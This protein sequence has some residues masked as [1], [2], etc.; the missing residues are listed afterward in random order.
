MSSYNIK[1]DFQIDMMTLDKW[2]KML[3]L[4]GELM[5][6]P[7]ALIMKLNQNNLEVL[8]KSNHVHNV[9][10]QGEQAALGTGL[11]CETVV[12]S[13]KELVVTNA[14]KD[15][16]WCNNPDLCRSMISYMGFPIIWPTGEIFGTIC[17]LDIREREYSS[18]YERLLGQFAQL[19]QDDLK[20]MIDQ[21]R[22]QEEVGERGKAEINLL[23]SEEKFKKLF[24]F[25]PFPITMMTLPEGI[26]VDINEAY[27]R[28]YGSGRRREEMIGKTTEQLKLP[29][30]PKK[31]GAR[32]KRISDNEGVPDEE[33]SIRLTNGKIKNVIVSSQKVNLSGTDHVITTFFDITQQKQNEIALQSMNER[34]SLA[35]R[36]A[37][38]GIW[39]W[40]LLDNKLIWNERMYEIYGLD[41]NQLEISYEEWSK[42]L[43]PDD[44]TQSIG[45][46]NESISNGGPY[47][48]EYRA[49]RPDGTVVFIKAQGDIIPD[50]SGKPIRM[51]GVN[52][53]ITE[54]RQMEEKVL[55]SEARYKSLFNHKHIVK[56][57]IDVES[58]QIVEANEAACKFYGFSPDEMITKKVWDINVAGEA[59]VRKKLW[60]TY[61][62]KSNY[63]E[64]KHR[65]WDGKIADVAVFSG[66][67][68]MDH[69]KMVYALIT[70]ITAKKEL[71]REH[72]SMVAQ[73]LQKQ[74][75]ES[76]GL[77]A[78]GVAHEINNP[79]FGII[80]YAKLIGR[81]QTTQEQIK[82]YSSEIVIES[83]R[84]A[85]IVK[86]L[87]NFSRQ[88]KHSYSPAEMIDIINHTVALVQTIFKQDQIE[89]ILDI[90]PNLPK[91]I[92]RS[93]QIQQVILN[94]ITNGRD[95]L[96]EKYNGYDEN[97]KIII[98]S[99]METKDEQDWITT[100]VED[101]G[102]GIKEEYISKIF[103]PFFTTKARDRGTGLGLS[104]SH[105]I[106]E[107]HKGKL[108][109]ESREGEY[110]RAYLELPVNYVAN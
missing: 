108:H 25:S 20:A 4:A 92:C 16:K 26:L 33:L 94:L 49:I 31:R 89:M 107:G 90:Q 13:R 66:Y 86:N 81:E 57:L 83:Q 2:Q 64:T 35:T 45:E 100:I 28:S 18:L 75:L 41:P 9:Y 46:I 22:I 34:I 23:E 40:N 78:G 79:I 65:R 36:A 61:N 56:L 30:D 5:D 42:R 52:V 1:S 29:G 50:D 55:A 77:L 47:N 37:G 3:D 21:R 87:L 27:L 62:S 24:M 43:H 72:E 67:L 101:R 91:L 97:K 10:S 99:F 69:C 59:F 68:D 7:A 6:V 39:D 102:M 8:L 51:L 98:R 53:D 11:Y 76:I 58:G 63:V 80:N 48:T 70:D 95:A 12:N 54:R 82:E 17:I 74:K 71:E 96:N 93:Q 85:E 60:E 110:T 104:I 88:E 103:D 32:L 38:I 109:F 19:I 105:G 84:I 44:I 15:P 106:V 14:L 73:L